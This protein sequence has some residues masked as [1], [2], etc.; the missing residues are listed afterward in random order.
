MDTGK[1]LFEQVQA[2]GKEVGEEMEKALKLKMDAL[3]A[4]YPEHGGWFKEGEEV[5]LKGSRFRV[6]RIKPTEIVL[7]LLKRSS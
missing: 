7:K 6:K 4:L 1:G 5:T 3:E 2:T